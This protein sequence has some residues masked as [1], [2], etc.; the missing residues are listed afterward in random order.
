MFQD[1]ND[2]NN[3]ALSRARR[4]GLSL[5]FASLRVRVELSQRCLEGEKVSCKCI[6]WP[7]LMSSIQMKAGKIGPAIAFCRGSR[8]ELQVGLTS[9]EWLVRNPCPDA[10]RDMPLSRYAS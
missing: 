6:R 2:R 10:L 7:R 4:G 1:A 9:P 8:L 3:S 5:V